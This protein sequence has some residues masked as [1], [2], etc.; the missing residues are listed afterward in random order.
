MSAYP[1]SSASAQQ[2][3]LSISTTSLQLEPSRPEPTLRFWPSLAAELGERETL[4]L[5]QLEYLCRTEGVR[6]NGRVC[7]HEPIGTLRDRSFPWMSLSTLRRTIRR[8]VN[9]GVIRAE[10]DD[11][12]DQ[13]LS[14]S[15]DP[16]GIDR[17]T[18]VRVGTASTPVKLVPPVASV[19]T[20]VV[21][22]TTD[23]YK[24]KEDHDRKEESSSS[25]TPSAPPPNPTLS[26]IDVD[27]L[28]AIYCRLTGNRPS[29][30]DQFVARQMVAV[31]R[32][33]GLLEHAIRQAV[34]RCPTRVNSLRYCSCVLADLC[35]VHPPRPPGPVGGSRTHPAVESLAPPHGVEPRA[36]EGPPTDAPAR[37][38][39]MA[40]AARVLAEIAR[41]GTNPRR[42]E[43]RARLTAVCPAENIPCE[44]VDQVYPPRLE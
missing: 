22:V 36:L 10:A 38:R 37:V 32:S 16:E 27:D 19:A 11:D 4:V 23:M 29:L 5:L 8:L 17:L 43:L 1:E 30:R 40:L 34:A 7:V 15:I 21:N 44:L 12:R 3:P 2:T 25:P 39:L 13:L 9:V 28:L 24:E 42:E 6:R 33:H 31:T 18:S 20:P 26:D 14:I 35:R 41:S